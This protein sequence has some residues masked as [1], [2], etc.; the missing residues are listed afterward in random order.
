MPPNSEPNSSIG[1]TAAISPTASPPANATARSPP[2]P[3][4]KNA[5]WALLAVIGL[6]ALLV[7]CIG[8][9]TQPYSAQAGLVARPSPNV[10]AKDA[11]V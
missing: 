3:S 9:A 11:V 4:N 6:A 1:A 2:L 7:Y 8:R 10:Y 5:L